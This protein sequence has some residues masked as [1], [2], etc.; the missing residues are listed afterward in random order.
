MWAVAQG[1]E[2]ILRHDRMELDRLLRLSRIQLRQHKTSSWSRT[3]LAQGLTRYEDGT[4]FKLFSEVVELRTPEA[5]AKWVDAAE[6]GGKDFKGWL[7]RKDELY[8]KVAEERERTGSFVSF[9]YD[10]VYSE[11]I[12]RLWFGEEKTQRIRDRLFKCDVDRLP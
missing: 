3:V 12:L 2:W 10:S 5:W 11:G 6:K 8:Q 9:N 7:R 4:F 1:F